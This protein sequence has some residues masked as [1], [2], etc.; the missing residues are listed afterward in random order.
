MK[1]VR[2]IIFVAFMGMAIGACDWYSDPLELV[3][4]GTDLSGNKEKIKNRN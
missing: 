1:L 4:P 3:Y 2:K